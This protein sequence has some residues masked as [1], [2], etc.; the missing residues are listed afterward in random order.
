MTG[1]VKSAAAAWLRGRGTEA[2]FEFVQ[3]DGAPIGS[4]VDIQF[5][6]GGLRVHLDQAVAPAWDQEGHEPVLGV[7]VP[8]DRDTLID[9]WYVHRIRLDSDG[10]ARRVRIGTEAFARGT[11]WFALDDCE[12]TE[13]GLSTPAVEQIVRSRSTRPVSRWGVAKARKA[14]DARARAQVLLRKLADA[15]RVESVLV[16]TQVRR[17]IAALTGVQG[18]LQEQL[19]AAAADAERWLKDQTQVRREL[20]SRLEDA[21]A[22]SDAQ[23]VRRL[24]ARVNATASHDR[25]ATEITLVDVAARYLAEQ[26]QAYAQQL[27]AEAAARL[28]EQQD[29]RARRAADRVRTLLA[30]LQRCG[31]TGSPKV[32]RK[33]VRELL[34]AASDAGDHIDADQQ[35]QIAVW[36]TRADIGQAPAQTA[37]P[38]PALGAPQAVRH[39]QVARRHWIKRNCPRC[40]AAAGKNCVTNTRTGTGAVSK[41]P[42]YERIEPTLAARQTKA[43]R[44]RRAPE[45]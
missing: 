30:T 38:A 25:T 36:K 17:D 8:V 9:R 45:A 41:S 26:R 40:G 6:R 4:V 37:R 18:E 15:M 34:H 21:L 12:M 13:R 35:E 29:A 22:S 28:A 2:D 1:N 16:V 19:A 3:P 39:Q 10:T 24:L 20:F 23:Q 32:M 27:Q 31:G 33:L 11:E 43:N 7:S 14:P 44:R 42:H 5:P